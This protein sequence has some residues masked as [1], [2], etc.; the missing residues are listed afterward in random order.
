MKPPDCLDI[1]ND[2]ELYD[3]QQQ[4]MTCDIPFYISQALKFGGPVLELACGTGRLAIPIAEAGLEIRGLD[5]SEPMLVM[6]RQKAA[7]KNLK[8]EFIRADCRDFD[9]NRKFNLIFVAFNSITHIHDGES[10]KAF[11]SSVRK[12]LS[13]EGR[14]IIDV[15]NPDLKILMRD[16]SQRYPALEYSL[17]ENNE[18]VIITENNVYDRSTQINRIKW[19]YKIGDREDARIDNLNMRIFYP[20]E[21]DALL[22]FNG[23]EMEVKYGDF[24]ESLF[25]SD[26][27]KQLVICRRR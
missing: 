25:N 20:Q 1:F 4:K 22:E 14:F 3:I 8:I 9:L 5:I 26:S 21:L 6:A 19:Y 7:D 27:P 10:I 23:F 24:D 2:G 15:F 18:T 12:H 13:A 11:F 17:P 16:P